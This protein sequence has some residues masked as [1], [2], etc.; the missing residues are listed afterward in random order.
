MV[1]S[2][3]YFYFLKI[4]KLAK[5]STLINHHRE[6]NNDHS[7]ALNS[8]FPFE[9]LLTLTTVHCVQDPLR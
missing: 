1:I 8:Q 3:T 9:V 6:N 7:K 4:R 5:N 2:Y